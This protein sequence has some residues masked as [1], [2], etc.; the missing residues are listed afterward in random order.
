MDAIRLS[1]TVG[2]NR[3]I[4]IQLP[5]EIPEGQIDLE[6][7]VL[8]PSSI[9][10][11]SLNQEDAQARLLSAGKLALY[12]AVDLGIPAD[13]VP[14]TVEERMRIGKLPPG[15]APMEAL[16]DEDRGER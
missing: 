6:L 11:H 7:R 14:L 13:T 9:L 4:I 15:V 2:K 12:S 1:A 8:S 16:V 10:A 5:D 3:Q